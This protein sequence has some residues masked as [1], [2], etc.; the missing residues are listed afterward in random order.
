MTG[1]LEAF[2]EL[3]PSWEQLAW[4]WA[5]QA[6]EDNVAREASR[7]AP[8]R[9]APS[10]VIGSSSLTPAQKRAIVRRARGGATSFEIAK[11]EGLAASAV[12]AYLA[13]RKGSS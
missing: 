12:R 7:V 3:S 10:R 13:A 2:A 4:A 6:V 9:A 8:R 1:I 11:R 5:V